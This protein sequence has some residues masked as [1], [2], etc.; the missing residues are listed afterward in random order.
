MAQEMQV[1]FLALSCVNFNQ[2]VS[3]CCSVSPILIWADCTKRLHSGCSDPFQA[4]GN[5]AL[6]HLVVLFG[7]Q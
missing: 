3:F 1:L 5:S 4:R 6:F 7:K 2:V